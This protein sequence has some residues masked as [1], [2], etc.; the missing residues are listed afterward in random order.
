METKA[1]KYEDYGS[2]KALA[3]PALKDIEPQPGRYIVYAPSGWDW[4]QQVTL[5]VSRWVYAGMTDRSK[6]KVPRKPLQKFSVSLL[7]SPVGAVRAI[8]LA[9]ETLNRLPVSE[10][11]APEVFLTAMPF[12]RWVVRLNE[13]DWGADT[14]VPPTYHLFRAAPIIRRK[15]ED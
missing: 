14:E 15:I 7:R 6:L 10:D 12:K 13:R 1:T 8:E 11:R 3:I 4:E 5:C 2:M 9:I